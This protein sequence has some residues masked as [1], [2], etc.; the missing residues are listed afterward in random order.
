MAA[1]CIALIVSV[2]SLWSRRSEARRRTVAELADVHL[3]TLASANPVDVVSTDKHTV[4]PWFAGKLPFTFNLPE[5]QNTRFKLVGG[6]V[7][8]IEK[9]PAAQLFLDVGKHHVSVYIVQDREPF[10]RLGSG[11]STTRDGFNIDTWRE[12]E[13][14]FVA[15]SDADSGALVELA[16]LF[17][18]ATEQPS[19]SPQ[20]E[21][22]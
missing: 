5:L 17:K 9:T 14:R 20:G 12:R 11:V 19:P 1:V 16:N 7:A 3:A 13:L 10:S 6:R 2:A 8:Y 4:K 21:P 15:V 22:R 18:A